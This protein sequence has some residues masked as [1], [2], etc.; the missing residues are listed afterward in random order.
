MIP[1]DI[2]LTENL[3]FRKVI[4]KEIPKFPAL[5][6]QKAEIQAHSNHDVFMYTPVNSTIT[7][8]YNSSSTYWTFQLPTYFDND[9]T[10]YTDP[11][12][13]YNYLNYNG[14]SYLYT[15]LTN[16]QS[17]TTTCNNNY[18][19]STLT[20]VKDAYDIFGNKKKIDIEDI[21]KIPWNRNKKNGII[22]TYSIPWK[23]ENSINLLNLE[24]S[25]I[26]WR[27][28]TIKNI[29]REVD[30]TSV[31]ER[32]K[33]L[34]AWL[35]DKSSSFIRNYLNSENDESNLSYLTNMRWIHVNDAIIG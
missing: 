24:E 18:I 11:T 16:Q 26:P 2:D 4:K 14:T 32:A 20:N 23:C 5:F 3:D 33:N 25:N 13:R 35:Q 15:A 12:S 29:E 10:L 17:E 30:L 31:F 21:P 8:Q 27:H 7:V 1:G 6:K 22:Y 28:Y 19:F 9:M 34:I